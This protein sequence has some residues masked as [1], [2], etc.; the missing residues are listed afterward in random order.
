MARDRSQALKKAKSGQLTTSTKRK[1]KKVLEGTV[2]VNPGTLREET[3]VD[4]SKNALFNYGSYV[5][6]ER[7]VPDFRDG[8]KPVHRRLIYAMFELGLKHTAKYRKSAYVVGLT[9]GKYHP[10]GDAAAY[11]AL[12]NL[13][14]TAPKAVEGQGN[15]GSPV[16][17]AA[18][19][20]YTECRLSA[21]S[22]LFL[23]EPDYIKVVPYEPNYDDT[24]TIPM[25]LPSTIPTLLLLGNAGGI[26]YGVRACN[27]SFHFEGVAKLTQLAL[28]G[29]KI[30][31]ELC[32]EHLQIDAPF[33]SRCVSSPDELKQ[34][35]TTGRATL[36]YVPQIVVNE[37]LKRVEIKSYAP[38]FASLDGIDKHAERVC[39]IPGVSKWHSNCGKK[40]KNAG[41]H[42]CYYYVEVKRGTSDQQL[43]DIADAMEKSLTGSEYYSLGITIRRE[44]KNGFHYCTYAKFITTW[45]K[46]RLKLELDYLARLISQAQIELDRYELLLYAVQN[47]K[48]I[49]SILQKALEAKSPDEYLAKALKIA[50]PK[51]KAILDMQVRKLAKL[52]EHDLL[53]TIK[54]IRLNIKQLKLDT[55]DPTPRTIKHL[56]KTVNTFMKKQK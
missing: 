31:P 18:A 7:A 32:F 24:S 10:H 15:W 19:Q 55:K 43:Y 25:Y 2:Q 37:K 23:L 38:G 9:L 49:L 33:G 41:P 29:R 54:E 51:A 26:A 39:K 28:K 44:G 45:A 6:E 40:N 8:L 14:N 42:G 12:V 13:A 52:E 11:G 53:S 56:V 3:M 22:D 34:F 21:F 35:I 16:D 17:N 36:K 30:T 5:V 48:Q 46:Y 4:F 27:P 47:R 50:V 1:N 20:R